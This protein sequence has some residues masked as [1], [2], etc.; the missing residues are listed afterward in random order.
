LVCAVGLVSLAFGSGAASAAPA[1]RY[2]AAGGTDAGNDCGEPTQPCATIQHAI[3]EASAGDTIHVAAGAYTEDVT[4]AKSVTLLGPNAGVDPNTASRATEATID[5]G[6]GRAIT[7]TAA[8]VTIDGFSITAAVNG[9]PIYT[10]GADVDRLTVSDDILDA[11]VAALA[12][13]A[14]GEEIAVER[15][16]IA[17]GGYGIFTGEAT[18]TDLEI[19]DNVITGPVQYYGIFTGGSTIEGFELTGNAV[20]AIS[21][22]SATITHGVVAGNL[23][24]G[25]KPG[26]M[27]LQID[28]H[29]SILAGNSFEGHGT[30]GCLQLF[31]SQYS[32][33]PSE[34][35]LITENSFHACDAY[36]IQLSPDVEAIEITGNTISDS[37]DGINTR[38]ISNWDVSGLGIEISANS[39]TGSTHLGVDNTV[40]G[41]LDARD[42]WW[43]CN[44]G[45]GQSGCDSVGAGVEASPYV[46]LTGSASATELE[47]DGSAVVTA[48]VDTD[49]SGAFVAGVP[50]TVTFASQLGSFQAATAN[51]VAGSA[52]S[53]FTAGSQPGPAGITVELDGEG[54]AVPLT[55]VTPPATVSTPPPSP[56]QPTPTPTPAVS[57][58]QMESPAKPV[59]VQ[60]GQPTVG[61]ISCGEGTCQ[62]DS[63]AAV[64]KLGG[65]SFKLK[66]IVPASISA[67]SSA[68]VK[69]VLP[70]SV[71]QALAKAG[72]GTVRVTIAVVDAN[73]RTVTQTIRVKIK[74]Q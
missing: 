41:A 49:S 29:E 69:V 42:N 46:V 50:G 51:L 25:E 6:V 10:H 16:L 38:D 52:G 55:I 13:E 61:T 60:G 1:S 3:D 72:T 5:G 30:T 7:V 2:V 21:D 53:T 35:V 45:P 14:G 27:T 44:G 40:E 32:L 43:G 22:I 9:A 4:I 54:V 59:S 36:G 20:E 33:D 66:V 56:P 74:R 63:K 47:F 48:A 26:E 70:K 28:L 65:K 17:G 73:G 23:F 57:E 34:E 18:Y 15:N 58:P 37:Y 62:V 12:L 19:A 64:A 8:G 24:N 71:R 68:A 31:G 39:I 67:G 11:T